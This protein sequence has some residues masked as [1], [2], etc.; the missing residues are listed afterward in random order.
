[1]NKFYYTYIIYCSN[2]TSSMYG[3]I[4]YGKHTTSNLLD[5]YIASGK[6]IINYIKKYPTGYYRKILGL[7][8][9]QE[10]LNKAEYNLIHPHLGKKYYEDPDNRKKCSERSK[11]LWQD[12]EYRKKT[13]AAHIRIITE[14]ELEK[15]S[16][17]MRG[18]NKG[19][20]KVW[21]N[22]EL[23]IYHMEY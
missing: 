18:K 10:E 19:K 13:C 5:G 20:H 4:Y 17:S 14:E 3:C 6:K 1:M 12:P 21:D 8:N 23:N 9:S 7:Y 2:P 11:K 22:K 15:R 16:K